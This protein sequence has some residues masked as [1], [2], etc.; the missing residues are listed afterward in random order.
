MF[1]LGNRAV[2]KHWSACALSTAEPEYYAVVTG[3]QLMMT[4]VRLSARIRVWKDSNAAKSD[5]FEKRTWKD[6]TYCIVIPMAAGGD[7]IRNSKDEA[8]TR[9]A[10]NGGPFDEGRVLVRN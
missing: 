10:K 7:Q 6:Q 4:D 8:G 5:C 1:G 3:A 9:R 2:V